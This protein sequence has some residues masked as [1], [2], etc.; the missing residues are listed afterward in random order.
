MRRHHIGLGSNLANSMAH[1]PGQ[2]CPS[3]RSFLGRMGTLRVTCLRIS[4]WCDI[5]MQC[6]GPLCS[7]QCSYSNTGWQVPVC[8]YV[9][10]ICLQHNGHRDFITFLSEPFQGMQS[11]RTGTHCSL[12]HLTTLNQSS[13]Q[14]KFPGNRRYERAYASDEKNH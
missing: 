11:P 14:M 8:I 3:L 5:G 13:A 4:R 7:S 12:L 9:D 2:G 10:C 1:V 6:K